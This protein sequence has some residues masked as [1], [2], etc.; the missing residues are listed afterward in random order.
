MIFIQNY[1]DEAVKNKGLGLR[2]CCFV[3]DTRIMK[4]SVAN[5]KG[6]Q[7]FLSANSENGT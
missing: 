2:E 7:T 6:C 3:L 1:F 5:I 4:F